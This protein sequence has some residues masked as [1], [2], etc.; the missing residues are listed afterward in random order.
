MKIEKDYIISKL[1]SF[2]KDIKIVATGA[3][4][5][6]VGKVVG[7]GFN[8]LG[9]IVL[10]RIL[11]PAKF[12]LYIIGLTVLRLLGLIA[13]LGLNRGVIQFGSRYWREDDAGLKGAIFQAV[14]FSS[15]SGVFVGLIVFYGAPQFA[16]HY[17]NPDLV[18]V[19]HLFALSFPFLSGLKVAAAATRISQRMRFAVF[20]EEIS[21]SV[22]YLALI[23]VVYYFFGEELDWVIGIYAL[24]FF[25][26]F[27]LAIYYLTQLF[28]EAFSSQTKTHFYIRK[29][30]AFSLPISITS[31]FTML[32]MW[33]DRLW[34]GYF[35]SEIDVGIYQAAAQIATLFVVII[36]S[37]GAILSP[38]IA[39]LHHRQETKRLNDLFKVSTRWGIYVSVPFFL[40]ICFA[41]QE[42][43]IVIFGEE[44]GSGAIPL[45]ILAVGQMLNLS[46]G[47][48]GPMLMMTENQN[49][50]LFTSL[51]MFSINIVMNWF[52]VPKLGVS[53]AAISTATTIGG[54]Y[55]LGL[56]QIK[57]VL[58]LWPYDRKCRKLLLVTFVTIVS[59]FC[60]EMVS[61]Q[62]SRLILITNLL[63]SVSVFSLLM[64]GF[65]FDEEDWTFISSIQSRLVKGENN[66]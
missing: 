55:L 50:W 16:Y 28:P 33:S 62:G 38:L 17:G 53:G 35:W 39:K 58:K 1:N 13:P 42:F 52:L 36:G 63:V 18:S 57:M 49:R 15:L 61:L 65:G 31:M 44:Y 6:I 40:T 7:R 19:M 60:L 47:V 2:E 27:V 25:I 22:S 30:L 32:L 37:F 66:R 59:L 51:G 24:S 56:F 26:A 9:Q 11:G 20:S 10:A 14:G 4:I 41:S 23:T 54:L 5:A 21:Q 64:I 48:V 8:V 29:L 3:G 46:T 12:G 43:I 34:I 45:I